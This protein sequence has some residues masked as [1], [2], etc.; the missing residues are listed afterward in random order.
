VLDPTQRAVV[1]HPGGPLLV[2]AGPGTGKTTTLIETVVDRIE[3]RG[4]Q[5][6]QVL[7]LT[8][9]RKA[10]DQLRARIT[11]RLGRTTASPLAS[12]FHSFAYALLRRYQPA[13]LFAQPLQL[14]SAPEQ[15]VRLAELLRGSAE[16]GRVRWPATLADALRT[17]GLASE[18][19]AVL[20]RSR[21]LGLDPTDLVRIGAEAGR[22]EWQAVGEFM[23]EYLEVLDLQG[24]IDY[25]ELIHRAVLLAETPDVRA[26]QRDRFRAVFVDE[27]QDTDPAQVRLLQAVAGDGRDLTVV[28]DPDQSIYAFRGAD[29]RGIGEFPRAF[30]RSDGGPAG[31]IALGTTRRFGVN[32][33]TASRRVVARIGAPPSIPAA[34][35]AVFRDP[36]A[37]DGL[38]PGRAE[39]LLFASDGAE[40]EHIADL[41]R[42]ARL[43]DG[44]GWSEMA[45]LVRSGQLS[46]PTLRRGL[47]SAGVPVEVAGDELPLRRDPAVQPLLTALRVAIEPTAMTDE[48]A[49]ALLLSPL[50][51]LDPAPLR[52]LG[53]ALRRADLAAHADER[54]PQPSARLVRDAL[55]DPLALERTEVR[56]S[57]GAAALGR[58]LGRAHDVLAAGGSAEDVLWELWSGTGWGRRLRVQAE[59]GGPAARAANRDLDA[60]CALFDLAARAEERRERGSVVNFLEEVEAQ[61]IPADT[62]AERGVRGDAVRLLTAHRAKGLEWRL[63]VVASVQEGRWPDLRRRGSLLQPER[64]TADGLADYVSPAALL[65]EERRLFYVA[66]TRARE[67][68]VV[69][70]VRS[71]EQEADQPSRFV[72]EL[73]VGTDYRPGR[74]THPLSL[75]GVVGDLRRVAGDPTASDAVRRAAAARLA[76]L[77]AER[78]GDRPLVAAADPVNWWGLRARTEAARP[79]RPDDAPVRL[80][81][82]ALT[83]IEDCALRWFLS[84]EAAGEGVRSTALGFGSV[85]HVLAEHWSN[86]SINDVDTLIKHL[87]SVWD[88]LRFDGD[89]KS[90]RE[91][92]DAHQALRRFVA[93]HAASRERTFIAAEAR[94][95]ASLTVETDGGPDQAA[96]EGRVDR[97]ERTAD[98][99]VVV[100]DFKTGRSAAVVRS[101]PTNPQLGL[102]QAAVA[103]D[104][105]RD[106]VGDHAV[107]GGAEL[108]QLRQDAHGMPRVQVQHPQPGDESGRRPVDVQLGHAVSVIRAERFDAAVSDHC[109]IC[110][111]RTMCPANRVGGGV[112]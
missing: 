49:T 108:V 56:G 57:S 23:H 61:T 8:F 53:R 66:C 80:S 88:Q 58:L 111:F 68:L 39:V 82:S 110:E 29:V 38:P 33:L 6:D 94:F 5:P 22:P 106:T 46:I 30:P 77:R 81:A 60:V 4:L 43:E 85:L 7:V 14:L 20:S 26:E 107:P 18:V 24:A 45:V 90:D 32:L 59:A 105:F 84:K 65:A 102:Y 34:Q 54:L 50:G 27:Y 44:V 41:L 101:L 47:V 99:S 11:G 19:H 71:S 3:H 103:A 86:E 52:V 51:G 15:D 12:T 100:V 70:A 55:L 16:S 64:L 37:A 69:T 21:D 42:R 25:S 67:R 89:W 9:S 87:D 92:L 91:R 75:G 104:G 17:R 97:L 79:V 2:L 74:L 36:A 63:V 76:R 83:S 28:G 62:L 72:D 48:Q 13:D 112:V 109:R 10:A 35:R 1:D 78:I 93:W 98:G 40:V 73:G 95:S 96:L 31:V